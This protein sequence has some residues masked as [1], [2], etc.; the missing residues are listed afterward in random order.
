MIE[1]DQRQRVSLKKLFGP[2][3]ICHPNGIILKFLDQN[4][5]LK[6]MIIIV[7]IIIDGEGDG[8]SKGY[9]MRKHYLY[10]EQKISTSSSSSEATPLMM[11]MEMETKTGQ[12]GIEQRV[13]Q[14]KRVKQ[15]V[16]RQHY[17]HVHHWPPQHQYKSKSWTIT[18]IL[19][20]TFVAW[21][22]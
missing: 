5:A 8:D 16:N 6:T 20:L 19:R 3:F 12:N 4:F 14:L 22:S 9:T 1:T 13:M 11:K 2:S 7:I 10:P 17:S 18:I 15:C 21:D